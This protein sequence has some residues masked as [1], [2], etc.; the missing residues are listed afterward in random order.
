VF[1]FNDA[2]SMYGVWDI[3]LNNID[4]A[5][6]FFDPV[7]GDYHIQSTSPCK[8]AGTN[9][10]PSLPATDLD[11]GPRIANGTVDLGCYEFLT[12]AA[13]SADTDTNFVLTAAEFSAYAA[14]WKN[15]QSWTNGPNPI[16]ANYVTRAGYLMTNGGTYHNDGSA[17]PV[18]WKVGP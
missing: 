5:P 12:A 8:D 10:A 6:Q 15:G 11:G 3:A 7:N 1:D 4:L 2:D 13:H 16:P 14:A 17:R 9:G 18:N